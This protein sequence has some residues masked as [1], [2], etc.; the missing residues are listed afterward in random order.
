MCNACCA[1]QEPAGVTALLDDGADCV[2]SSKGCASACPDLCA[3]LDGGASAD[4]GAGE[5]D[6]GVFGGSACQSCV[7]ALLQ[8]SS[9][10]LT[11]ALVKCDKDT[12]CKAF[13]AC[14]EGCTKQ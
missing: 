8:T 2:C 9:S 1:A 6:G 3:A 12:D 10:C 14:A 4:A 11:A 5:Q 13:V 7:A